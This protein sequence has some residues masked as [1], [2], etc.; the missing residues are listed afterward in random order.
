MAVR[1]ACV[2]TPGFKGGT[3]VSSGFST[4]VT[5]ISAS[6]VPYWGFLMQQ[7]ANIYEAAMD[8]KQ[9]RQM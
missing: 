5:F 6:A 3:F 9:T 2:A 4:D 8:K 7:K 1:E